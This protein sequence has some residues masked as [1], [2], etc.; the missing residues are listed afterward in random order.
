MANLKIEELNTGTTLTSISDDDLIPIV[1]ASNLKTYPVEASKVKNYVGLGASGF[2]TALTS[3]VAIGAT[4]VLL[5]TVPTGIPTKQYWVAIDPC[6]TSSECEVKKVTNR[7]SNTLTISALTYGHAAD[8]PILIFWEPVIHGIWFYCLGDDSTNN[9]TAISRM[10]TNAIAENISKC[11]LSP[12]TYQIGNEINVPSGVTLRGSG[13]RL[14]GST[15]TIIKAATGFTDTNLVT[16]GA[17]GVDAWDCRIENM[18]FECERLST[19]GI[20]SEVLNENSGLF[21]VRVRNA[22]GCGIKFDCSISNQ[23]RNYMLDTIEIGY[24]MALSHTEVGIYIDGAS[25][26]QRGM[27]NISV[28]TYGGVGQ[29]ADGV[30]LLDYFAGQISRFHFENCVDG[31]HAGTDAKFCKTTIIGGVGNA[32]VDNTI[33]MGSY[34]SNHITVLGIDPADGT[35]S[36]V[37]DRN[38]ISILGTDGF[39][40]FYTSSK[41]YALGPGHRTNY[42][43]YYQDNVAA[44]QTAVQLARVDHATP[45]ALNPQQII[46]DS[47]GSVVEIWVRLSAARSAGTLTLTLYKNSAAQAMTVVI[48]GSNTTQNYTFAIQETYNFVRYDRLDLRI[49]TDGSWAPITADL[50]AGIVVVT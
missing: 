49:T 26:T 42:D 39:I 38:G 22:T 28:S 40:P 13:T 43:L 6:N 3:T 27:D 32:N 41:F 29:V 5:D 12:G 33:H 14:S 21:S 17:A 2:Y 47:A 10:L 19:N 11:E 24:N 44:S 15:T 45:P 34:A 37:D 9:Y 31:I 1:A 36:I 16:M 8:V 23:C 25:R 35:Y 7:T 30:L 18:L 50:R 20:Y 46:M 4:T 48:D